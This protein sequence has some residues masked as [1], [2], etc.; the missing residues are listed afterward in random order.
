MRILLVE[1]ST[2]LQ[3]ALG[4]GLR[5]AGYAID[6]TG[7]GEEGLW[8]AENN[9]YD[10]VI[11]DLL[12][13]NLDGLTLLRKIRKQGS[14]AHVLILSAKTTLEDKVLGL[15]IGADDYLTKPFDFEEL[16]ARVQALI[17]RGYATKD[18]T[19]I[20]GSLS[21]DTIRKTVTRADQ[22]IDLRPTEYAL[23]EYL[24]ERRG[25]PVSR[26]EI[27]EHIYDDCANHISNV[28]D[29]A[30]CNLR[31]KIN[32]DGEPNLIFTRRGLGYVLDDAAP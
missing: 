16:L 15:R 31:K 21:I 27:E 24:A 29:A 26:T 32:L 9:D 7:D 18:P 4:R 14:L 3:R 13:P 23:L 6:I 8:L 11:L 17:R 1:D 20:I 12:L 25:E 2:H 30:I 10:V 5:K 19:L 28:V 22:P